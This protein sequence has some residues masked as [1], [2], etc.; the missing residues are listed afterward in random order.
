MIA[1]ELLRG[2]SATRQPTIVIPMFEYWHAMSGCFPSRSSICLLAAVSP[3]SYI[4]RSL[5]SSLLFIVM[6][7]IMTYVA[8]NWQCNTYHLR[9]LW[10]YYFVHLLII[11]LSTICL[12]TMMCD[13][14]IVNV[15]SLKFI[16][17]WR[18]QAY[19]TH[20]THTCFTVCLFE[21]FEVYCNLLFTQ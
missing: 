2:R 3:M 8:I 13:F 4:A 14:L 7:S 1:I 19:I 21:V 6:L 12:L 10:S 9:W 16:R 20:F 17:D 11:H 5:S 18:V 15:M